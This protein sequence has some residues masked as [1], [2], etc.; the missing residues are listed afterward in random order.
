MKAIRIE[1]LSAEQK[2]AYVI[3]DNRLALNAGWDA[4]IL[5]IEFAEL[6]AIDLYFDLE[7]TGFAT[8]E[9]DLLIDGPE[10]CKKPD[11]ADIAPE[12][13]SGPAVSRVRA[14]YG[15]LALTVCCAPMHATLLPFRR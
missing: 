4:E 14:T 13:A 10:L 5:Q 6:A 12:A 2:R 15:C 7:I 11:L 3:A 8:A 9:I 1:H